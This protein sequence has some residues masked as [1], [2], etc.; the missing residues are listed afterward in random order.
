MN[1]NENNL[2]IPESDQKIY[3][4][5]TFLE[6]HNIS[7][8][9]FAMLSVGILLVLYQGVGGIITLILVGMKFDESNVNQIRLLTIFGQ[10]FL[11]LVPALLF[12]RMASNNVSSYLKLNRASLLLYFFTIIGIFSLQQILQVY[13]YFQEM[14]PMPEGIKQLL[15]QLKETI[16]SSYKLVAGAKNFK[17]LMY[18]ILAVAFIPA[19]VEETVFRGFLQN[20]LEK[21]L[22]PIKSIIIGGIIFGLFHLN[23]VNFIPLI[24]IGIYL[25]FLYYKS[26]SLF[27]PIVAHF[28]NNLIAII[29]IY[30]GHEDETLIGIQGDDVSVAF[31]LLNF[32]FF[33]II[34]LFSLHYFIKAA[35]LTQ[36][37]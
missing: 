24:L 13:L 2:N 20:T 31:L 21:S 30:L 23:P 28:F 17:E 4:S 9:L 33:S 14:I 10:I 5:L 12:S 6:K 26:N 11:L 18:V 34:F 7:P 37:N 25:G 1:I 19:I 32:V 8:L 22:Y 3:V 15:R 16:E 27:I 36:K 29:S 35:N